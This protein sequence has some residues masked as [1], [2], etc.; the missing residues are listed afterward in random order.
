M[1]MQTARR[2]RPELALQGGRRL[3]QGAGVGA[4][5]EVLPAAVADD[6]ADVR[7]P[8]GR[9]LLVGD[10]ERG[11]QD[12]AGRDA[13]EDAFAL[14]QLTGAVDGVLRPD[15]EPRV[16]QGGVVE[17]WDEALVD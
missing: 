17:L 10:A 4:G 1:I 13:G 2:L 3:V 8:A 9:D 12:R 5:G 11:V 15:R 14:H 6:E 7:V 16:E